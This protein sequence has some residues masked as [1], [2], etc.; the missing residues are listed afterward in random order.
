V[1]VAAIE[2]LYERASSA[3]KTIRRY[4]GLYHEC[5]NEEG[6]ERVYDDLAAW[7]AARLP[8]VG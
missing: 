5:F 6:R 3:D 7:L 1:D 2:A 8:A 4:E